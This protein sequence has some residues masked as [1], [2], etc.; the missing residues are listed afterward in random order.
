VKKDPI[1]PPKI[2]KLKDAPKER[3]APQKKVIKVLL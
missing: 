3:E 2:E 1:A